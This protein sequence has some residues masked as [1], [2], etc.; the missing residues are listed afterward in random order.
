MNTKKI[1]IPPI[2]FAAPITA[3]I[4]ELE[5]VREKYSHGTTPEALFLELKEMFQFFTAI[6]SARIEGNHTTVI[7][8]IDA[9]NEAEDQGISTP[10]DVREIENIQA[11]I[12]FIEANV[13][14][15][16]IDKAFILELHRI[17]VNDLRREGDGRVGGW[18]TVPVHIAGSDHIAP[19]PSDIDDHMQELV[20]FIN[21]DHGTQYDLIKDAIVHHRFVWIHPFGNG[22]GRVARL[23]TY[24]MMAK[25]GFIDS[26]G[27]RTL[28]PTAVF[29]S[30]R[31][32]YYN[33]LAQADSLKDADILAWSE[34]MLHGVQEDLTSIGKLQDVRFV[35][36]QILIPAFR[37]AA[38]AG[39]ITEQQFAMLR[40]VINK[41]RVKAGDFSKIITGSHAARSQAVRKLVEARLLRV[42]KTGR[43]YSLRL[44]PNNV[45]RFIRQQLDAQGL[46][47]Q[48][49]KDD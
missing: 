37:D 25:Q 40:I 14:D 42:N 44:S 29:G 23:L 45:T 38:D 5:R 28:N 13:H 22:N 10:E 33:H 48:A 4:V 36:R 6:I 26:T 46:L 31:E 2:D 18:R 41:D 1:H 47:P 39:R 12:D 43:F 15:S 17:V 11:G 30:N 21:T 7:D 32:D 24:A 16:P 8:V 49:L 34:F 27:I 20:G 19:Q 9:L 35:R 3:L